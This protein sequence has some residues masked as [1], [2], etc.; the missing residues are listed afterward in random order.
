MIDDAWPWKAELLGL[1]DAV[2]DQFGQPSL[3]PGA[4]VD[5]ETQ[6]IFLIERLVFVTA[7][8]ARK[9]TEAGNDGAQVNLPSSA[10]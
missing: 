8:V 4:E 7:L 6:Q 10:H 3:I 9:L 1:C 2:R 5:V